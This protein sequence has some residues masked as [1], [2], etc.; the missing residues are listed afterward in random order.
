MFYR[1]SKISTF[2]FTLFIIAKLSSSWKF[3][4]NWAKLALVLI[5]TTH[6]PP[7]G[8]VPNQT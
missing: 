7:P 8:K 4:S 3:Y 5:N 1:Q 6:P 2:N